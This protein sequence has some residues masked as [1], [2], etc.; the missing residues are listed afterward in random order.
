MPA[1]PNIHAVFVLLLTVFA[2]YL[3]TRDRLPLEASGLTVL[4]TLIL[5]FHLFP[6]EG[7]DGA[8][9]DHGARPRDSAAAGLN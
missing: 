2:L 1:I 8:H 6:Y 9:L 5:F 4:I 7:A 3:F